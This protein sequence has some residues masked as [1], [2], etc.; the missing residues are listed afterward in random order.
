LGF[1]NGFNDAV[2]AMTRPGDTFEPIA[3]NVALYS[4]LY[5]RVYTKI[6]EQLLPIFKEMQ[7][8]T[9]YPEKGC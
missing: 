1:F 6:Y 4:A 5:D 7:Q 3:K 8:I 9:G 2:A